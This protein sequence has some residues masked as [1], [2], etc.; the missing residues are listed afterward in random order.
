MCTF[1]YLFVE[2]LL[3]YDHEVKPVPGV[4]QVGV[5]VEDEA[6]GDGLDDHLC[7]VDGQEHVPGERK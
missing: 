6:F 5:L 3:T 1:A 4:A 2:H 7:R